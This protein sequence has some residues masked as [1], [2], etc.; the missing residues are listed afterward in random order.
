MAFHHFSL[1]VFSL[2]LKSFQINVKFSSEIFRKSCT[3][4]NRSVNISEVLLG[5]LCK[6][7]ID[8]R[9]KGSW[10]C[11]VLE[12]VSFFDW[13]LP[14]HRNRTSD[15]DPFIALSN[16]LVL[17]MKKKEKNEK[18]SLTAALDIAGAI[19]LLPS[20]IRANDRPHFVAPDIYE[21]KC[22]S[23]WDSQIDM[24]A[25]PCSLMGQHHF[26][27]N[28][29]AICF[30]THDRYFLLYGVGA[31]NFFFF[32]QRQPTCLICYFNCYDSSKNC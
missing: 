9:F 26:Q 29:P 28:V 27:L 19:Y 12:S 18:K 5:W 16:D 17:A 13:R 10:A 31:E 4:K 32:L 8:R 14:A 20:L 22:Y 21:K 15:R 24:M 25:F 7:F 6:K 3:A 2:Y 30:H 1:L 11:F 23:N